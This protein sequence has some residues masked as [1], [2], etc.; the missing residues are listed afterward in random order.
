MWFLAHILNQTAGEAAVG[1]SR[2]TLVLYPMKCPNRAAE[3]R[4]EVIQVLK[5]AGYPRVVDMSG[6]E[7]H[8]KAYFEGTGA[9][10]Q[11]YYP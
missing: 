5:Q 1:V 6:H 4:T 2:P 8:D 3:R 9:L 10:G 7:K 11:G